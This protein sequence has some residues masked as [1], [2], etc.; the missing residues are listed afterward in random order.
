MDLYPYNALSL[1]KRAE[2]LW[3]KGVFIAVCRKREPHV[4]YY[5]IKD[6]FIELEYDQTRIQILGL[7]AFRKGERYER[8]LE[9]LDVDRLFDPAS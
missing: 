7:T 2:Q 3:S 1:E 6:L 8:M 4:L 9:A 5:M